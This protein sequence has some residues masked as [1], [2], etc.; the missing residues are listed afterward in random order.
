MAETKQAN[1]FDKETWLSI[2]NSFA[3]NT[4][5]AIGAFLVAYSQ[6]NNWNSAL[7]TALATYGAFLVNIPREFLKGE[8]VVDT[9]NNQ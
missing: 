8:K 1:S 5:G 3:L 9:T 6:T 4:I 2:A 7:L